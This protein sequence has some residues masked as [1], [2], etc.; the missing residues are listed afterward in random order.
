MEMIGGMD[1]EGII[2]FWLFWIYW[3]MATFFM[4]KNSKR[5]KI[6]IYLLLTIILS[7]H[8]ITL[9]HINISLSS[10][11]ILFSTYF[12]VGKQ[13]NRRGSYLFITA[14]IIMLAYTTFHFFELY[15]PVWLIF[16]RNLMLAII[17]AY[18]A[19]LLQNDFNLRVLTIL[20]GSVHGEF[21]YALI[22]RKF[23]FTQSVGTFVFLDVLSI[24]IAIL[25]GINGFKKISVFFENHIKHLEREKQKQS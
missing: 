12:L 17:L 6:S 25:L 15:D 1:M 18:L 3:I 8:S 22:F 21:L 20:S 19:I 4:K 5:L 24:A 7:V 14:F 10:L 11:F 2:F 13:T 9:F 16:N 23:A